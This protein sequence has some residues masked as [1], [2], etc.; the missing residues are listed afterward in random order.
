M[1]VR[2]AGRAAASPHRREL[3]DPLRRL[4]SGELSQPKHCADKLYSAA[5]KCKSPE[6]IQH[7]EILRRF[8]L[9]SPKKFLRGPGPRGDRPKTMTCKTIPRKKMDSRKLCMVDANDG[10]S[11]ALEGCEEVAEI[12]AKHGTRT[13]LQ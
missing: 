8:E 13:S 10:E 6:P 3:D 9:T 2:S 7:I 4:R 11:E 1:E 12:G 5:T